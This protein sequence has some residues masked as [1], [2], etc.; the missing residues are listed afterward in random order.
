[1]LKRLPRAKLVIIIMMICILLMGCKHVVQKN[2][3]TS[4][5]ELQS[6]ESEDPEKSK[7]QETS[8]E[9]EGIKPIDVSDFILSDGSNSIE[10]D[11]LYDDF[12]T[13]ELEE[14]VENNY[15]GE[16]Y[17]EEYVYKVFSHTYTDFDLYTSNSNYNLKNRDFDEYHITQITLK[18]SNYTTARGITI[19]S[20]L[21]DVYSS[22]MLLM[23]EKDANL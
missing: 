10:L 23:S 9:V 19:G 22:K 20:D 7:I 2:E 18:N 6:A 11:S 8:P 1:M 12:K 16:I 13:N 21:E 5:D 14:K 4:K 3:I 17:T 15:V